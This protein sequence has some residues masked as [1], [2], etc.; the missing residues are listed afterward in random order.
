MRLEV[1]S[2]LKVSGKGL[3]GHRAL[4]LEALSFDYAALG[5]T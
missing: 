4:Q 3:R 2:A 5:E 1:K